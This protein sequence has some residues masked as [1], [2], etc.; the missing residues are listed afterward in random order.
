MSQKRVFGASVLLLALVAAGCVSGGS[1]GQ[2]DPGKLLSDAAQRAGTMADAVSERLGAAWPTPA[3][4]SDVATVAAPPVE[5]PRPARRA[6][7]TARPAPL[8]SSEV[9][10][11]PVVEAAAPE[12]AAPIDL[13]EAVVPVPV[14]A[15]EDDNTVYTPADSD[16]SPPRSPVP[17]LIR[18]W[19]ANQAEPGP[20]VEVTVARDGTVERVRMLSATR[21]ADMMLLSHV[22]AWRFQ[23]AVRAGEAVRYRVRLD[24]PVVAP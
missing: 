20:S 11:A 15:R 16:V 7:R 1:Q 17:S 9:A 10:P 21:L 3:P 2:S 8:A 5:E 24:D 22:K 23:P 12:P 13:V 18:P 6:V 14:K 19:R 4:L